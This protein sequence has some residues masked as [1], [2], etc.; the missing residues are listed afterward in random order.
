MLTHEH[1]H[2][3]D[4]GWLSF[5]LRSDHDQPPDAL[6]KSLGQITEQEPVLRVKGFAHIEGETASLLVQGVRT[7]VNYTA[8]QE[9]HSQG[10]Q[11]KHQRTHRARAE[12]VFIGYHLSRPTVVAKL[13]HD[14]GT[15]WA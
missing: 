3:E 5:V 12:L 10:E 8:T 13:C 1:L 14:T 11:P 15:P 9:P 6:K 2:V 7:R 4:P